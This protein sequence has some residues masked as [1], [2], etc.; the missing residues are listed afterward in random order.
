MANH[1]DQTNFS[2]WDQLGVKNRGLKFKCNL[3]KIIMGII[4]IK[5]TFDIDFIA[6]KNVQFLASVLANFACYQCM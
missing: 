2:F 4:G 1:R 3:L 6:A 5:F